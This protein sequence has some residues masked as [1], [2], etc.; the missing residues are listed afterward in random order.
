MNTSIKWPIMIL[1]LLLWATMAQ[2]AVARDSS[3]GIRFHDGRASVDAS[4]ASL[5]GLLGSLAGETEIGIFVSED[6]KD[7][8][9]TLQ[10]PDLP[11]ETVLKRLLRS[12]NYAL[13]Y[14]G[15]G[16]NRRI[17]ELKVFPK[18]TYTGTM[19]PLAPPPVARQGMGKDREI[20]MVS[21]GQ[22]IVTY[23]GLKDGGLLL[24]SWSEP[25][26]GQSAEQVKNSRQFKVQ[27]QFEAAEMTMYQDLMLQKQR[28]ES[29]Q[30][31][32]RKEAL[33]M[34]YAQ[35]V[36]TFYELKK[37]NLNKSEALKRIDMFRSMQNAADNK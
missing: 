6:L 23:G 7:A 3:S 26:A 9:V 35:E 36:E 1:M 28:I 8:R 17:V 15:D 20:V 11:L 33:I 14:Q 22:E 37:A 5:F 16:S 31:P 21:S 4:D 18:G 13:V 12:H 30:D 25:G 10:T 34:A 2:A 27:K 32:V 19:Q 24:P 29:V